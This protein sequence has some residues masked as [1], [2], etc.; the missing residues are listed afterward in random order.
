MKDWLKRKWN[1]LIGKTLEEE[2]K[3]TAYVINDARCTVRET[4]AMLD[5]EA[6]WLRPA[7]RTTC[8]G[9]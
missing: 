3:K 6:N 9:K 1:H 7:G 8:D 4:Q 5:G 2:R